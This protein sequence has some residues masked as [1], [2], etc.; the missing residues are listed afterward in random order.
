[1][2]VS[3][4]STFRKIPSF[5]SLKADII[6]GAVQLALDVAHESDRAN[7]ALSWIRDGSPADDP[8]QAAFETRKRCYDLIHAVIQAVDTSSQ[9]SPDQ[10]DGHLTV[11]AKRRVEAYDVINNSDDEV[12]QNNLYDW[13]M[14]QGWSDRLLEINSPYVVSYLRRRMSTDPAHADLLWRYYAHHHNYLEAASVQLQLAKGGFTLS[15]EHRIGYLSRARTNASIRT[16]S[17]LDA[18]Q[19]RQQLLRE[20]TDLLDVANIQDDILQRM[21]SETRLTAERRPA[22]IRALDGQILPVDELFNQYADQAGYYD[23]CILIYNVAD[24]RNPADISATWQALISATHAEALAAGEN[25]PLPYEA[26]ALKVRS[27]GARLHLAEAT[28]PVVIILPMLERYALEYQFNVGPA[29]WVLDLFLSLEVPHESLLPVLESLYYSAEPPF[30][31]TKNRKI[32]A[33][34]IVYLVGQWYIVSERRGEAVPFGSEE[35]AADVEEVL[36]DLVKAGGASVL[37]KE[38]REVVEVLRTRIARTLR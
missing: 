38:D 15:L 7:R 25:G 27:L 29:H 13:Y 18:Q 3:A 26:V 2:Q 30:D 32:I 9:Q 8:R 35:V 36:K 23:I 16:T 21:K 10:I 28:F 34:E 12:F 33:G 31:S 11:T 4:D 22:V 20:I 24:H 5:P 19:S 1:M 37:D 6:A 17:L 14:G